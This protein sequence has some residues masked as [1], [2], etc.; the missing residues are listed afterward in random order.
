MTQKVFR[1]GNSLAVT[2]PAR[3]VTTVGI[4]AGDCVRVR[5]EKERGRLICLFAGS[6]QMV[7]DDE[8]FKVRKRKKQ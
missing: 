2:I 5:A 6:H 1:T 3:F 8:F 7:F 4:K